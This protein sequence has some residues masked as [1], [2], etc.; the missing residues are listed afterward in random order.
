MKLPPLP[1]S[2]FHPLGSIP[3]LLV[4]DL[5]DADGAD[6]FGLWDGF[7][8]VI[9]IRKNMSPLNRW[10]T[11]VHERTHAELSEIGIALSTD[12]EEAICNAIATARVQ[13]MTN[14]R[15]R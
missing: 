4:V 10:L 6:V 12:Q 15:T 13:E 11:L 1:R 5:K 2:V 7:E 3:V 8:R 14:A 9:R